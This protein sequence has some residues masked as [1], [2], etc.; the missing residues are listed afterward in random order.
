MA[1]AYEEL[2]KE[3]AAD[4]KIHIAELDCTAHP[5]E[6]NRWSIRGY[7]TLYLITKGKAVQYEGRRTAE[8]MKEYL[9]QA[10]YNEGKLQAVP[11]YES[12]VSDVIELTDANFKELVTPMTNAESDEVWF[13]EFFAPWCGACKHLAP[14]WD[15]LGKQYKNHPKIRIAKIDATANTKTKDRWTVNGYPSIYLITKGRYWEY[16]KTR[17]IEELKNYVENGGWS[18]DKSMAIPPEDYRK[19]DEDEQE[20]D[21]DVVVLKDSNFE[22]QVNMG[23]NEIWFIEFY[24]VWCGHCRQLKPV[25]E[26]VATELK[27]HGV[28]VGKVEA[29]KN[30][31]VSDRFAVQGFPTLLVVSQGNYYEYTGARTKGALVDFAAG[32]YLN[33]TGAPVQYDSEKLRDSKVV[34]LNDANFEHDT[35]AASGATTGDWFVMF[36]AE[37]CKP[38]ENMRPA[39]EYVAQDLKGKVNVAYIEAMENPL[40]ST[41]FGVR[42]YPTAFLISKGS[43]Y[44]FNGTRD[45]PTLRSF[46]SKHG[47]LFKSTKSRRVPAELGLEQRFAALFDHAMREWSHLFRYN[48]LATI[49]LFGAGIVFGSAGAI[50][51]WSILCPTRK[52]KASTT[53]TTTSST[54]A[55]A[56]THAK[57]ASKGGKHGGKK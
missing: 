14:I 4:P 50:F 20:T 5:K 55:A 15:K 56:P 27:N 13:V 34:Y 33:V 21:S 43:F 12:D 47:E 52:A 37:G 8:A 41:R 23:F 16:K 42:S 45:V 19:A 54:A 7:P 32:G 28:K 36:G 49:A 11:E 53:T 35:Q 2:G 57:P 9:T 6:A 10:K 24:A 51:L 1:A 25:W 3:F 17:T 40:T 48:S 26:L 30:K 22:E 44:E 39:W 18:G 29:N 31:K 38:C 46:A